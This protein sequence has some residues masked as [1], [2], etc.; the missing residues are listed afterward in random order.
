MKTSNSSI[1]KKLMIRILILLR[2]DLWKSRFRMTQI[3]MHES[4]AKTLI[5]SCVLQPI[6]K[7]SREKFW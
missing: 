4:K 2:D 1:S 7:I 3:G 5:S 6:E